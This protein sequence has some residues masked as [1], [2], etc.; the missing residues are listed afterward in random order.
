MTSNNK[1]ALV[2]GASGGV[3][4]AVAE[5]LCAHGWNVRGLARDTVKAAAGWK[6]RAGSIEWLKGDAMVRED[7]VAAARG[8]E[9]IVHAVSP[10]GYRDWEKLVLPMMDNTIAAARMAGA[11]IVLPGT[12]Y[13][14][15]PA[16]TPVIREDSEQRPRSRKGQVRVELERRLE[17]VSSEVPVLIV[18]AGDFYGPNVRS[19]W[20]AQAMVT[21]GRPVRRLT[22][23]ARGIGHDWAYLPDLAESFVRLME[24]PRLR[25]FERVGFEGFWDEDGRAFPALVAAAVGRTRLPQI[26]FP[27][28]LMRLAAPFGGFPREAVDIMPVWRHAMRIDNS[29]LVELVGAEPRTAPVDAMRATLK[30]LGC[31]PDAV[32]VH[33]LQH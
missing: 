23:L 33:A 3:G 30:G 2:L 29:R 19:S 6:D 24:H 14:F 21:P 17:A 13:N 4:G 11:R 12:V 1:T 27:W 26:S 18:R 8:V 9:V 32:P 20:F 31:L 22:L 7:V 28:W 15:D 10:P 25:A 5:A 16:A